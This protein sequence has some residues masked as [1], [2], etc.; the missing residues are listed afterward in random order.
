MDKIK[1]FQDFSDRDKAEIDKMIAEM[2][3][4]KAPKPSDCKSATVHFDRHEFYLGR[5]KSF[6]IWRIK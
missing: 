6:K 5:T 1:Q 4:L 3:K 2:Q